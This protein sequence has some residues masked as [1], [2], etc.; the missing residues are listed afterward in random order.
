MLFFTGCKEPVEP[1]SSL[2]HF[3]KHLD[4]RVPEL[5]DYYN[6]PGTTI[7]L[8]KNG[9]V[10]WTGR[11]GY[12]D[13]EDNKPVTSDTLFRA[14]SITKSVVAWGVMNLVEE[15]K[16]NLD[17]PIE[18]YLTSWELPETKFSEENVTVR[19]LLSHSSGITGGLDREL[20]GLEKQPLEEV[21]T[22]QHG[23]HKARLV[24]EP[25]T[26]FEYSNQGYV[27]LEKIVKNV[28]DNTVDDYIKNSVIKLLDMNDTTYTLNDKVQSRH[29]C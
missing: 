25:G 2:D 10:T 19:Q 14:E 16:I 21:L 29:S 24:R 26:S 23:L 18:N 13:L 4:K 7:T 27:I 5:L 22:G 11:Y 3:T 12:Q 1:D 15:G 20:P 6:I 28:T 17:D 8:I 9:E